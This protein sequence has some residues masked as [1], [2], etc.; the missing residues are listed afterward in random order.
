M[1]EFPELTYGVDLGLAS[2]TPEERSQMVHED[3][4]GNMTIQII[5]EYCQDALFYHPELSL[6]S[7]PLQ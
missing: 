5:C 7:S 4:A 3:E 1:A 2:L 6:Q